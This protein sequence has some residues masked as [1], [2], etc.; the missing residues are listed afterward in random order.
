MNSIKLDPVPTV[1][2]IVQ[3]NA[4]PTNP[5]VIFLTKIIKRLNTG[6]TADVTVMY[7]P[8]TYKTLHFTDGLLTSITLPN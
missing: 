6:M 8:T 3:D 2:Q 1:V 5:F 4:L 7:S